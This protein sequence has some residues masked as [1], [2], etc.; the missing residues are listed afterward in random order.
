MEKTLKNKKI[1]VAGHNGMVGSSILRYLKN[2]G[3]NKI[4]IQSRKKLDLTNWNKVNK[5]L[6]RTKPNIVI[7]C[8]GKVGGILANFAYPKEFL[9]ENIYIQLNLLDTC[10]KNNVKAFINLGSSCIY[11]K[12][13]KQ[14]IKE[15]CLLSGKLEST[16][17]AYAIAKIVGLKSCEFYNKQFKT[18][19]F[20]LMPCN[21]YGPNDNFDIRSSHFIPGLIKKFYITNRKNMK[22]IEVWGSGKAKREIM[23]VDDLASAIFFILK[24]IEEKNK[25]VLGVLKKNSHI[26]IGVNK[27]YTIKQ[28]AIMIGK[29]F[30]KKINLKFNKSYPDGTPRKLLDSSIIYGMGWKPIISTEEGLRKTVEWY[31]KNIK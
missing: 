12:K 11:P 24:K 14:P 17:E 22:N 13:S 1:F 20:T 18:N 7:N 6:K 10:F 30:N 25:K 31:K 8:A 5:F 19:Y 21:M 15:D 9:F 29:L 3:S 27:E 4:I 2:L 16:N 28:F 26:N 23:H